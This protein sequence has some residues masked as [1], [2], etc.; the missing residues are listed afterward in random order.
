M[1]TSLLTLTIAAAAALSANRFVTAG[2]AVP[3]ANGNAV[4]VT[5]VAPLAGAWVET[6]C[7][8]SSRCSCC[9]A[10]LAGAWVETRLAMAGTF[11]VRRRAPRG[12]V[13]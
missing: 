11:P 4:G 1:N 9:V 13:G 12:R 6:T 8:A 3:S 7:A 5:R 2:G 10:P